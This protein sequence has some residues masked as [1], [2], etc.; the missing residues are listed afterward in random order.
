MLDL[1]FRH[2]I[3]LLFHEPYITLTFKVP[4]LSYLE[5]VSK[6]KNVCMLFRET[7]RAHGTPVVPYCNIQASAVSTTV[8]C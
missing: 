6:G 4:W 3:S 7:Y 8:H 5:G 1:K 2:P